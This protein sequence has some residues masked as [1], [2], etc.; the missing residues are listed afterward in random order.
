MPLV[1]GGILSPLIDEIDLHSLQT[2]LGRTGREAMHEVSVTS[3]PAYTVRHDRIRSRAEGLGRRFRDLPFLFAALASVFG[4]FLVF[5]QPPG[6][7]LDEAQHFFH[8]WSM[9]HGTLIA[10]IHNGAAGGSIP[11]CVVNYLA[12]FSAEASKKGPFSLSQYWASPTRCSSRSV[13][14]GLGTT[15]SYGPISYLPSV[16]AVALLHGVGAPLPVVFFLGRLSSL[17]AYIA[18]FYWAIRIAPVGKQVFFVLGLLPTTLLLASSYSADPMTIALAALSVA[19]TLRCCL[20]AEANR[21][22]VV[23]LFVVLLC[24]GLTKPNLFVFA[25]LLF[26]VP[27]TLFGQLRHRQVLR[28]AAVLVVVGAAGVWYLAVRHVVGVP[29]PLLGLNAHTQ[30]QYILHQP[31]GYLGV[32]ARTFFRPFV[33]DDLYAPLGVVIVGSLTVWYS[34]QLQLGK[35][36]IITRG[37][38]AVAWLPIGLMVLG[39][40]IIE[41]S[42][43][44]YGTPVGLP[45]TLA[46]GRYFLPMA[47]LPLL[48]IGLLREPRLRRRSIRWI[49]LGSG[50]LLVWLVLKILVHD[51]TL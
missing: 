6:Q 3:P 44:I 15:A 13:F 17:F 38:R 7:G 42:L 1:S 4:T 35:R 2:A 48:S 14:T 27:V 19:L 18:L 9:A 10:P 12:R 24:L 16:I 43:F 40:L 29:V 37:S 22:T 5:A 31:I 50:V 8:V 30:T 20:D 45:Y 21:R 11:H 41:T 51:F 34:F 23:L 39:I 25:P 26:M 47:T 32:L 36:R 33:A 49:V 28:T 46:Q